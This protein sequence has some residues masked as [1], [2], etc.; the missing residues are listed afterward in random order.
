MKTKAI[1]LAIL[2]L[3]TFLFSFD[4]FD[5]QVS[6]KKFAPVNH[7]YTEAESCI[8]CKAENSSVMAR[9][10]GA[11]LDKAG[12]V[13]LELDNRGWLGSVHSRS[14]DHGE[15]VNNACAWCHAPATAGAVRDEKEGKAIPKG[16]WQGVTCIACH[17][18]L[19][20][21][22]ALLYGN[23]HPGRDAAEKESYVIRDMSQGT[24]A[25]KLC[26]WCHHQYHDFK[27]EAKTE[28]L[29][30]GTLRCID[31]HMAGYQKHGQQVERFHNMKVEASIPKSCSGDLGTAQ[32]CHADQSQEWMRSM[33]QEVKGPR[34]SW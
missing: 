12:A 32:A 30:Q 22:S 8:T 1:V 3:S 23:Y 21:E 34:K 28:M 29:A 33:L 20:Q 24:E 19:G 17:P 18:K 7:Q 31:C 26:T 25:N 13:A 2:L 10:V 4:L 5:K 16:Q 14:Q 27:I 6:L 11:R 15:R 9:A